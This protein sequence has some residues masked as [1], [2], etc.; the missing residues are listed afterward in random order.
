MSSILKNVL[1]EFGND[2][3]SC[4]PDGLS[5]FSCCANGGVDLRLAASIQALL[6]HLYKYL[7]IYQANVYCLH[8][9]CGIYLCLRSAIVNYVEQM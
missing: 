6:E 5:W 2:L 8:N 4:I 3:V 9:T 7:T 1:S